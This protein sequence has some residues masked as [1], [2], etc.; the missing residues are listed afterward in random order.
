MK[1]SLEVETMLLRSGRDIFANSPNGNIHL[2][3]I[4]DEYFLRVAATIAAKSN[5]LRR[6]Y[7]AVIVGREKMYTQS[8][9]Y[10]VPRIISTGY[11]SSPYPSND[12]ESAGVCWRAENNIPHGVMYEQCKSVHAEQNALIGA[13]NTRYGMGRCTLYLMGFDCQTNSFIKA[14]PCYICAKML[15]SAKIDTVFTIDYAAGDTEPS[16]VNIKV[17]DIIAEHEKNNK[18]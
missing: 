9:T 14:V 2:F 5:C 4:A 3:Y 8:G 10:S 12:C 13:D 18:K 6:K 1:L 11:N 7:G 15:Y 17:S 16:V